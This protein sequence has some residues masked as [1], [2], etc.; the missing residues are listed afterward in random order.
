MK[1]KTHKIKTIDIVFLTVYFSFF[2][3]SGF[4]VYIGYIPILGRIN[5][6]YLP[7]FVVL[8]GV[9]LGFKGFLVG[10]LSFGLSS[11][12]AAYMY[13]SIRYQ[14]ID[15]SVL[16]RFLMSM[17]I[18]L[19]Y[20]LIKLDKYINIWG[21]ILLAFLA[22]NLNLILVL[23]AQ[24]LHHQISPIKGLLPINEWILTHLLNIIGEPILAINLALLFYKFI[25]KYHL[26]YKAYK[27]ILY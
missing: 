22:S 13:G 24:H 27:E 9:H 1:I 4:V 3:I 23:S 2:I 5:L 19:F 26:K 15:I 20:K 6:T 8:A 25:Y 16:P 14:Y 10:G 11:L 18:Y 7:F 17:I 12:I 21:F